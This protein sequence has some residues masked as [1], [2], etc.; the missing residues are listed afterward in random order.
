MKKYLD[1]F[2]YK[3]PGYK[4]AL[5]IFFGGVAVLLLLSYIAEVI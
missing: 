3:Y 1:K 5:I 4:G 2:F